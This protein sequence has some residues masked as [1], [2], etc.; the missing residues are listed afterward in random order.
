MGITWPFR[1]KPAPPAHLGPTSV[2]W[3][4]GDV[5]ECVDDDWC[6]DLSGDDPTDRHPVI[7][8][9]AMVIGIFPAGSQ[10]YLVLAGFPNAWNAEEFRKVVL[11]ETGADRVVG[12][13]R[14][15]WRGA[16]V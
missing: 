6:S 1:R 16:T 3:V 4:P 15:V 13:D 2:D 11:P 10:F 12:V 5:A 14:P 7:G 9:R 8:T